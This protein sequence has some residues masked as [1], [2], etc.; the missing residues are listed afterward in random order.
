MHD[1]QKPWVFQWDQD[2]LCRTEIPLTETGE[3]H[4]L[5]VAESIKRSLPASFVVA[6]AC[7]HEHPSSKASEAL[8]VKPQRL[9]PELILLDTV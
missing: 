6:Q 7:A 3:H 9:S 8:V 5:S 4:V 2:H 1:L